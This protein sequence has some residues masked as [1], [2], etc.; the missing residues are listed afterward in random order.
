M[1][2]IPSCALRTGRSMPM[3]GCG[4]FLGTRKNNIAAENQMRDGLLA[5]FRE[6]GRMVDAAQNYLN[7]KEVG[8][9]LRMAVAEGTVAREDVFLTS[10]LN[11]PYHRK[12]H[13]REALMKTL[14]DLQVDY[15]DLYLIHWPLAF[16]HV[17]FPPKDLVGPG[18]S[19]EYEPDQCSAVTGRAWDPAAAAATWPPPH[20]D[21]GVTLHETWAAVAEF[22]KEGLVKDIGVC[23]VQVQLL[24]ELLCGGH[25]VAP[26]VVQAEVHPFLQ[27]EGLRRYCAMAGIQLQGYAPLGYGAFYSG[28]DEDRVLHHPTLRRLAQKHGL[29]DSPGGAA[30]VVLQWHLQRG[31]ATVPMALNAAERGD[32]LKLGALLTLD[33][34]DMA[35]VKALDRGTRYLDPDNWYGMPYWA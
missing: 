4:T 19:L 14:Q 18:L 11:N 24:H 29:A 12:A 1:A 32:N 6:G 7:E 13:A 17:P 35:A 8:D 2:G 20:L 16:V 5:W 27:Q 10:K 21:Y 22:Q 33:E 15:L 3:L 25:G 30:A 34:G 23:N 26:A 28:A 31:V 9:A